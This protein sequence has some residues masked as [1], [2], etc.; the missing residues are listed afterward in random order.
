MVVV[1]HFSKMAHFVPCHT[2]YDTTQVANLYFKKTMR[3]HRIHKSMVSDRDSKLMSHF[4]L[5]K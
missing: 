1:D 5:T 2:T 3:L 4:W